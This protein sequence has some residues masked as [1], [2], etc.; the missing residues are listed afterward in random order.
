MSCTVAN[1][2]NRFWATLTSCSIRKVTSVVMLQSFLR[3]GATGRAHPATT[4]HV[5]ECI[6]SASYLRGA[7]KL[8]FLE[9]RME[10]STCVVRKA[11]LPGRRA[12]FQQLR[13][14]FEIFCLKFGQS[15]C[16]F[17][18]NSQS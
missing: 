10:S 14:A 17:A 8:P 18:P 13:L 5:G 6:R 12:G 16:W 4:M 1:S 11:D 2:P 15:R 7:G 3:D 9:G